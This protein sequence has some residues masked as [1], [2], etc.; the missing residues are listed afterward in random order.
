MAAAPRKSTG[1]TPTYGRPVPP[2]LLA[3]DRLRVPYGSI[4]RG[5][6]PRAGWGLALIAA[7]VAGIGLYQESQTGRGVSSTILPA[8]WAAADAASF[9]SLG[10]A[11]VE[12][13]DPLHSRVIGSAIVQGRDFHSRGDLASA[14]EY[15]RECH[16]RLRENPNLAMFDACAA[17]D[18]S[19]LTLTMTDPRSQSGP[20]GGSAVMA[21]QMGRPGH[22]R[23]I[24]SGPIRGSARSGPGSISICCRGSTSFRTRSRLLCRDGRRLRRRGR[25]TA[26]RLLPDVG[27]ASRQGPAQIFR[28]L[29]SFD[30]GFASRRLDRFARLREIESNRNPSQWSLFQFRARDFSDIVDQGLFWAAEGSGQGCSFQRCGTGFAGGHKPG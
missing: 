12:F 16:S 8:Q 11:H 25:W 2:K 9:A 6:R 20:F 4:A 7:S 5:G 10:P 22:F 23:T 1:P 21:R 18:E 28:R 14:A 27:S 3:R 26:E 17:F 19:T 15:S 29:D 24:C 13:G 30:I